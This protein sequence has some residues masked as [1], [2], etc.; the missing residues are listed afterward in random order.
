MTVSLTGMYIVSEEE[1]TTVEADSSQQKYM[2]EETLEDIGH[3]D[4]KRTEKI[5]QKIEKSDQQVC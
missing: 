5:N 4:T 2:M 3:G 1:H